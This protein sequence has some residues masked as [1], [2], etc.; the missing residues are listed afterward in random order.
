[1]NVSYHKMTIQVFLLDLR[2]SSKGH[3]SLPVSIWTELEGPEENSALI[4]S[5]HLINI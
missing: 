3:R 4:Q 5:K 2:L 1:M